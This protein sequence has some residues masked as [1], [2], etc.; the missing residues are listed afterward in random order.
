MSNSPEV[1][2][3]DSSPS[4]L[5]DIA[6][7][8]QPHTE[9][10]QAPI[11]DYYDAAESI[12]LVGKPNLLADHS[13]LGRLL[14]LG[15]VGATEAYLRSL[16]VGLLNI[17]PLCKAHA[18]AQ[19]IPFA[20]VHYYDANEVAYGL[21]DGTSLAGGPEIK[22]VVKK[23]TDIDLP[24]NGALHTALRKFDVLCHLRH[25]A[26]HAHG[27]IGTG[28][29][30]ALGV[31]NAGRRLILDI[32]LA[33]VHEAAMICR[34]LV[35]EMN[36]HLFQSTFKKWRDKGLLVRDYSADRQRFQSLYSLFRSKRDVP[37]KA[38]PPKAAY[39]RLMS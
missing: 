15:H 30:A 5:L 23:L 7:A 35:Q 32:D 29:A 36:Q 11:D 38:L 3:C 21:F 9:S 26:V 13:V 17:C 22:K 1:R 18:G 39:Q 14:L 10:R 6:S 16:L 31:A 25:A 27:S 4:V 24:N 12:T 2:V 8:C 28:N 19:V 20:S 37:S 33:R 34:S